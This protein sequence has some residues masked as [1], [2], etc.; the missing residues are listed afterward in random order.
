MKRILSGMLAVF[1][2]LLL[3]GCEGLHPGAKNEVTF[4]YPRTEF[5]FGTA[6][7]VIS[8]E[9]R[10]MS[11]HLD[12]LDYL[13]RMYLLGPLDKALEPVFPKGTRL[14]SWE[15]TPEA[16]RLVL[17]EAGGEMP[18]IQFTLACACISK[19]FME[20]RGIG[21]VTVERGSQSITIEQSELL[22]LDTNNAQPNG[23]TQ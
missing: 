4:Y 20:L 8:P 12:D 5:Q 22:L 1:L 16:I 3:W 6:E 10:D 23:G 13:L 15:E 11:G 14:M 7:G 18:E 19:T 17:S 9:P 21:Q 2:L